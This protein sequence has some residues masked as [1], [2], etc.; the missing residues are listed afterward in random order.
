MGHDHSSS[1]IQSQGQRSSAYGR[2]NAVTLS[3]SPRSMIEDSFSSSTHGRFI[4]FIMMQPCVSHCRVN[5]EHMFNELGEIETTVILN[6]GDNDDDN[7]HNDSCYHLSFLWR[8]E[9]LVDLV[10]SYLSS[11][12]ILLPVTSILA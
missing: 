4:I 3:V 2:D 1:G 5:L 12:T 9:S 10:L 6:G 7:D 8:H 11:K